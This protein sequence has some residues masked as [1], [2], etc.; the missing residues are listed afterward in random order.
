MSLN[1][2]RKFSLAFAEK[3]TLLMS[4]TSILMPKG[5]ALVSTQL[6]VWGCS[7]SDRT[8]LKM[9][10]FD[11]NFLFQMSIPLKKSEVGRIAKFCIYTLYTLYRMN[12]PLAMSSANVY[13]L[14]TW[15]LTNGLTKFKMARVISKKLKRPAELEKFN[16]YL[17]R[18]TKGE[19]GRNLFD[20]Q[21]QVSRGSVGMRSMICDTHEC[22][23]RL[24][25]S[26]YTV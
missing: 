7:L 2:G 25:I 24:F 6:I 17:N 15:Q 3:S 8:N 21:L 12:W 9:T 20:G 18:S 5:P 26:L 13:T 22:Q 1:L 10:Q 14:P 19:E 11:S 4:T 23:Y 16:Q